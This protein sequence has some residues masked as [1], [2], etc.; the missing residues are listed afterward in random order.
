MDHPDWL[1][2]LADRLD[3][4]AGPAQP[5][6]HHP[7]RVAV[8]G[9][10]AAGKTTL[11][12]QLA[13]ALAQRGRPVI[14]ASLDGFH[15]PRALRRQRGPTSPD[16][17]YLDSFNY[18]ALRQALLDP[19]G[20]GGERLYRT[21]VF[22]FRTDQPVEAPLQTAAA[23]AILLLD[24][25]FLLRPELNEAWD[26][27]I[28]V[29]VSFETALQRALRRDLA[30][31]G[32][33]EAIQQRYQARYWPAQRRYLQEVQPQALADA[34]IENDQGLSAARM[35]AAQRLTFSQ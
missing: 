18:S 35:E 31:F 1:E 2:T 17:Y 12:N 8:D 28:F 14:R 19:L 30:L 13:E 25:V 22:D 4:L 10:D 20:P 23:N 26:Y 15:N 32:T 33:P 3:R 24:G 5:A 16:G 34:V 27:R 9:I 29:A 6:G 21:A 7:W 11:A